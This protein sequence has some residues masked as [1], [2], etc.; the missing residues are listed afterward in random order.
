MENLKPLLKIEE[1]FQAA[2]KVFANIEWQIQNEYLIFDK[3]IFVSFKDGEY[4]ITSI[5]DRDFVAKE[6]NPLIVAQKLI[7]TFVS[8]RVIDTIAPFGKIYGFEEPEEESD[9]EFYSYD[10]SLINTF[11]RE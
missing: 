5:T 9:E 10:N 4:I 1:I 6:K 11:R 2:S 3:E 7:E 8:L